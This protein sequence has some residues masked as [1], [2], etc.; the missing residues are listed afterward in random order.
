MKAFVPKLIGLAGILVVATV[1][2]AQNYSI[3]GFTLDGGGGTSTGDGFSLSGT[4]GQ[5]DAGK[6]SGGNFSLTG[7]FWSLDAEATPNAPIIIFDNSNGSINGQSSASTTSWLAGR[8]CLGS[9]AYT[10]DS[11]T[12]FLNSGD[13]SG[14]PHESTV[15]LR[16]FSS[17][18][19]TSRPFTNTGPTMN[20]F[21]TTNPITL[22]AGNVST[23]FKWIPATPFTLQADQCF[24][25]VL[26]V[27]SGAIA[28]QS[29][30]FAVPTGPAGI[31]GRSSSPNSGVSW[32]P[33]D[34]SS[35][36]KMLILGTHST[37]APRLTNRDH[38]MAI[39]INRFCLAAKS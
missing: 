23:P 24:W 27:Q 9:Q 1:A 21:G 15:S 33:A 5:P 16:I 34:V 38:L 22:A 35:N 3:D 7:G 18:P 2:S 26:S 6:M 10:L 19:V 12:L 11:V 25:A 28:Y 20:L 8:F 39:S 17:D 13:S 4:I 37:S 31:L 36:Y 14:K 32:G 29:V 30:T